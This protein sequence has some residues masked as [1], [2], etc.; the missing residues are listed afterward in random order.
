MTECGL[1]EARGSA[2][3]QPHSFT[4]WGP[5]LHLLRFSVMITHGLSVV[6][7]EGR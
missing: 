1:C 5:C 4:S 3:G 2:L 6:R 7:S